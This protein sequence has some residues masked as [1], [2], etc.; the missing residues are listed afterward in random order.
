MRERE[1]LCSTSIAEMFPSPLSHSCQLEQ[2]TLLESARNSSSDSFPALVQDTA[3]H[4]NSALAKDELIDHI[5]E[6][7]FQSFKLKAEKWNRF[8]STEENQRLLLDFLEEGQHQ[9]LVLFT[10]PGGNLCAGDGQVGEKI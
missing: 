3:S 8:I 1:T 2:S 10:G 5:K 9:R 7:A 4:M 6:Q